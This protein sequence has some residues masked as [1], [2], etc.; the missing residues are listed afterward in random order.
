MELV[1][2]LV[3]LVILAVVLSAL[4]WFATRIKVPP[5]FDWAPQAIVA[6]IIVVVLLALLFGGWSIPRLVR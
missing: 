2:V 6:L 3:S 5:P 1:N 4:W